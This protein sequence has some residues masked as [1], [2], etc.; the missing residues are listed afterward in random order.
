MQER[1]GQYKAQAIHYLENAFATL[2]EGDVEKAGEFLWGSLAQALKGVA[3]RK[4]QLLRNHKE[5]RTYAR[6]VSLE[7]QDPTVETAFAIADRLH[8]NFYEA[9]LDIEDLAVDAERIREA[10]SMLLGLLDTLSE[11]PSRV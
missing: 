4:E 8:S 2:Q 9:F 5:I 1:L 6:A 7:L 3:A 10:V 11:E